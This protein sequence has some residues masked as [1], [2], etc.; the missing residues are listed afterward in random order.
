MIN[1]DATICAIGTPLGT[2]AIAVI[3]INGT[4]A[5]NIVSLIFR[6]SNKSKSVSDIESNTTVH[7]IIYDE[8]QIIDEVIIA[9][10]RAPRSYTGEDMIEISCHGSL[11][12]Q[13]TLIQLLIRSGAKLA[14]PGEFTM[15]AFLNGKLDLSQAEAVADLIVSESKAAHSLAIHQ[16]RGGFSLEIASLRTKLLEFASLIELELDFSDE[17]LEFADRKELLLLIDK[18]KKVITKLVNSF[19][20]GNVLK[21]GVPVAIVGKTNVGKSTLLNVLLK[22]EKAIV[23]DIHG[24]TRDSIE[25]VINIGGVL[26]RFIDTAGIRQTK[27]RLESMGIERTF[28]KISKARIILVLT[29]LTEVVKE[30]QSQI[31]AIP[32]HDDQQLIVILNKSDLSDDKNILDVKQQLGMNC[33]VIAISAKKAL[34]IEELH[35]V[36]I[37]SI[38]YDINEHDLV[39]TNLR[40]YQALQQASEAIIRVVEGIEYNIG[41]E[42]VASDLKDVLNYLGE[43]TGEITTND[44]LVNIFSHFCI[45]K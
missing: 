14:E 17:E 6:P 33:P 5:F 27:D 31:Q 39:V 4:Q 10:F 23:S 24:T 15:R 30:I 34:N 37:N 22:E 9:C 2:G 11:Y 12:I 8:E 38:H 41:N 42:L 21:N 36:L 44:I 20:L 26:F 7:G 19:Q 45:G 25:E 1:L 29:D 3:R 18:I 43:I 32:I 13:N 35:R 16:M 40:H 28:D